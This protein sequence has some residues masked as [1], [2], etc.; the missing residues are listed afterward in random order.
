MSYV[1]DV[2]RRDAHARTNP[3]EVGLYISL[4]PQLVAGPIVRYETVSRQIEYRKETKEAFSEGV[5]R[6]ITGLA[7]KLIIADA[8]A[9]FTDR[10]CYRIDMGLEV[11]CVMAW[12]AAAS[13]MLQIY[14][15]FSAYSDMAIGLGKMFGF[16]FEENFNYPYISKSITEFWRRWHISLS[17]WFRDYVY[18][19]LGGNRKGKARTFLNLFITWM[20]T[21][22]WHGAGWTYIFWG[23]YNFAFLMMEKYTGFAAKDESKRFEWIR[24]L[25]AV[26]VTMLGW[27]IFRASCVS[28][29][30]TQIKTMFGF[31]NSGF[32][33]E[34]SLFY[35][36]DNWLIF[37]AAIA[38]ST[39]LG[40]K[41]KKYPILHQILLAVILLYCVLL[42]VK[43]VYSPFIYFSF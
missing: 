29:A 42:I 13:Y 40:L 27:V 20:L 37:A 22:I 2:Y 34:T 15:D 3:L 19:P 41:I 28:S 12:I 23:L 8:M 18:I 24:H 35:L 32:V 14:F 6:F 25:Y 26:T 39:P 43:Q 16:E 38:F 7:K 17:S 4:F 21:G 5:V 31:G 33:D 9:V 36:K 1:I 30:V 11:S 10:I